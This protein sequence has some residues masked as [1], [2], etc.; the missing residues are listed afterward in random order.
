MKQT[1]IILTFCVFMTCQF[2]CASINPELIRKA[3]QGD[4]AAQA[5]LGDMYLKRKNYTETVKWYRMAAEQGDETVQNDLGV[6][7]AKGQGV[8]QD[9]AEAL[10][11]YRMAAEKGNAV[12]M[13]NIGAMYENGLGVPQN[14][15]EAL[16]W[17]HMAA[18]K[19]NA[20]AQFNIGLMHRFGRGV[21]PNYAEAAKWYRL[22]AEQGQADAIKNVGFLERFEATL[23]FARQ[24]DPGAQNDTGYMYEHG[25]G[26]A[27]NHE[28]A[29][30]WYF[31]A[32]F[33]ENVLGQYNVACMYRNGTG[34]I[35]NETEALA[36]YYVTLNNPEKRKIAN[37][38]N[39]IASY[40]KS[41]GSDA[42]H[43]ARQRAGEISASLRVL[44][45]HSAK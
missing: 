12:A 20:L 44:S 24:G 11:W 30:I 27:Q 5:E 21:P 14:Y 19:G 18:E 26:V 34:C 3:G 4:M 40:E 15:T 43:S 29:M 7:F 25:S 35:K 10:K 38:D 22:A 41:V 16:K 32:A 33:H 31:K 23:A 17:F 42:R 39:I 45:I 28:E 8:T 6:I 9:Y 1:L 36:W 13:N 37:L 2:G